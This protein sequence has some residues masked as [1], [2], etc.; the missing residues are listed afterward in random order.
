MADQEI[1]LNGSRGH[2]YD[3][4]GHPALS[5]DDSMPSNL[6]THRLVI[7]GST[8]S[9]MVVVVQASLVGIVKLA[10]PVAPMEAWVVSALADEAS[11]PVL[12]S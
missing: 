11:P 6:G 8:R 10:V 9:A 1:V 5:T 12:S 2:A 7:V 4:A 3:N